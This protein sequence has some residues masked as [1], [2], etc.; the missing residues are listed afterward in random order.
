MTLTPA[1]AALPG[2]DRSAIPIITFRATP[3]RPWARVGAAQVT[4]KSDHRLTVEASLG[5]DLIR[6]S[7]APTSWTDRDGLTVESAPAYVFPV[8]GDFRASV[9][10]RGNWSGD[11]DQGGLLLME[12]KGA[13]RSWI[14]AGV[15]HDGGCEFV[16]SVA[17]DPYSN[18]CW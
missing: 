15:E 2:P 9:M 12:E 10:I 1:R 5:T 3:E 6:S 8:R 14:K 11:W 4:D 18:W 17:A 16:S 7:A 13:P